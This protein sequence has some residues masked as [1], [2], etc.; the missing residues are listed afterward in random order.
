MIESR[1]TQLDSC[2]K[3]VKG[4][5][6]IGPAVFQPF[7]DLQSYGKLQYWLQRA[8]QQSSVIS[9]LNETKSLFSPL[10]PTSVAQTTHP[11]PTPFPKQAHTRP[12][13]QGIAG[14]LPFHGEGLL[15]GKCSGWVS[16]TGEWEVEW[17]SWPRLCFSSLMPV[18]GM[19]STACWSFW[20]VRIWE[21]VGEKLR[22]L[23]DYSPPPPIFLIHPLLILIFSPSNFL[24]LKK[25]IAVLSAFLVLLKFSLM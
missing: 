6:V 22:S 13:Q 21:L 24:K 20:R 4:Q 7:P 5:I 17:Q 16:V 3:P 25:P 14:F 18:S 23:P 8:G 12:S 19:A 2:L 10:S 9:A 15:S 1:L 11:P